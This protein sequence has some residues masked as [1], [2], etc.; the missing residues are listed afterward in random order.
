MSGQAVRSLRSRGFTLVE[1]LVVTAVIGG[2]LALGL[3][4]VQAAREVARRSHCSNNLRQIGLGMQN[5]ATVYQTFPAGQ[6]LMTFGHK[7]WGWP[8]FFLEWIDQS[9]LLEQIDFPRP[10]WGPENREA[11][12][13]VIGLYLCPST[14]RVHP[15]RSG[16]RIGLDLINPGQWDAGTGEDMACIDYAG[17]SG[18]TAHARFVNPVTGLPYPV[19]NGVLLNISTGSRT[20]IRV[21]EISDGLSHTLLV[22]EHSGR[23]VFVA[24]TSNALRGVWAAGQNCISIPKAPVGNRRIRPI[25]PPAADAW[26]N[27]GN[28][29]LFS[30]H[31]GGAHV[32]F[33][34]GAVRLLSEAI[35]E[36]VLL[37]LASRNGAEVIGSY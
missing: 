31:P 16:N 22:G 9:A 33:C 15:T 1:L 23:G 13:T 21:A 4:A 18:A 34:D 26:I 17:I 5:Y 14:G 37:A 7:T 8:A 20:Q 27:A 36:Q 6:R 28:A 35:E 24:G 2:L 32:L 10:L 30:D 11:V 3:P 19:N 12:A 29:S 25:N